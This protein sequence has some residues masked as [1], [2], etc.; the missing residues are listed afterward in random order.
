METPNFKRVFGFYIKE[1]KTEKKKF[2]TWI[3]EGI[4][5]PIK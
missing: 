3:N 4:L 5:R 1:R 2:E